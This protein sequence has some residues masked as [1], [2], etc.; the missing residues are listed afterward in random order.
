MIFMGRKAAAVA[1]PVG[2]NTVVFDGAS[3]FITGG[4]WSSGNMFTAVVCVEFDNYDSSQTLVEGPFSLFTLGS[5]LAFFHDDL[6]FSQAALPVAGTRAAIM[7]AVDFAGGLTGGRTMSCY[8]NGVEILSSTSGSAGAMG[9]PTALFNDGISGTQ[10]FSGNAIEQGWWHK[11]TTRDPATYYSTFFDGSN[12]PQ[13]LPSDG[14][15]GGVTPDLF[16][17]GDAAAWN[18]GTDE[19]GNSY[20]MNGAVT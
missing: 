14:A 15:V 7:I 9:D 3:D 18:L 5:N 13:T 10:I 20:T 8:V 4:T 2:L 6:G 11:G 19:N 1:P 17:K 12:T 16:I